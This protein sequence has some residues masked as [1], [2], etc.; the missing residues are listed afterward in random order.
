MKK[1][2]QKEGGRKNQSYI[3]FIHFAVLMSMLIGL[4]VITDSFPLPLLTDNIQYEIRTTSRHRGN[5]QY[6]YTLSG[7]PF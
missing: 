4:L 5:Y 3:I 7:S 1:E 6:P 2:R